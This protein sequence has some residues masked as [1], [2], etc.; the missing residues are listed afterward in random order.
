MAGA[1]GLRFVLKRSHWN[2]FLE[3]LQKHQHALPEEMIE[4]KVI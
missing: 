4:S 3:F 2:V 1:T